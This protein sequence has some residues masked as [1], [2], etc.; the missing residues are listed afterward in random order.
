VILR[1]NYEELSALRA[2]ARTFLDDGEGDGGAVA[3]PPEVRAHVEALVPRLHGDLSASTLHEVRVLLAAVSA[4]VEMLRVEMET[5]VVATHPADEGAVA[6][7]FEFAHSLAV[8]RR[9]EDMAQEMEAMIEVMTG[10]PPSPESRRSFQ[11]P[12]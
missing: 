8:A 7:Y 11:F 12:D 5:L 4:I 10:A 9:L 6:A 1:C 2:G 3:A